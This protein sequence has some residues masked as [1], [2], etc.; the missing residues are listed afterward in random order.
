MI[1]RRRFSARRIESHEQFFLVRVS[2]FEPSAKRMG[3]KE[4]SVFDGFQWWTEAEIEASTAR[5]E[6]QRL[7][8]F[9]RGL[10][11]GGAPERPL[12]VGR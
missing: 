4:R 9:L 6:P 3:R 7:S 5:F 11:S 8:H 12:D 1:W 10:V 2:E